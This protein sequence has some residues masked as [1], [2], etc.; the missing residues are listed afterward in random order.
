[1]AYAKIK[2]RLA[3]GDIIVLDGATGTE[4]ER[5]GAPMDPA[6][7]CGPATLEND[8]ILTAIHSDY[9]RA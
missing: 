7:W 5:R 1:M 6:A 3:D 4:L 9:I 2:Q 8:H